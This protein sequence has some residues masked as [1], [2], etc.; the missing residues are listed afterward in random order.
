M[1]F[2]RSSP[3]RS[4]FPAANTARFLSLFFLSF[5]FKT[6]VANAQGCNN[7]QVL[8]LTGPGVSSWTAPL[9]GGPFSVR[10][11]AVGAGGGRYLSGNRNGGSGAT[12]RG[13]FTVENGETLLAIAGGPGND[14]NLEGA[15]GGG[16]S[17]VVNCGLGS[18]AGGTILILA[19]G[20]TGGQFQKTG[21]GGSA[22]TGGSG[23]G[24]DVPLPSPGTDFGGGGGGVNGDGEDDDGSG[25]KGGK[26]VSLTGLAAGGAG[27]FSANIMP[28]DNRGGDGMGGGG[29]GGDEGVGGGG[30]HTGGSGDNIDAASSFNSGSSPNNSNGTTGGGANVGSVIITCLQSL[31]VQL[32]AFK[33]V[34]DGNKVALIWRTATEKNNAGFETERSVDG[35]RWT[36]LGFVPGAG[37][38]NRLQEYTFTDENPA[39][40]VNYY[41]LKQIDRDGGVEYSHIATARAGGRGIAIHISPNPSSGGRFTLTAKDAPEGT[42]LLKIC[43]VAGKTVYET[44]CHVQGAYSAHFLAPENLPGGLYVARLEFSDGQVYFN[45]ILI[46]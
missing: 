11:E 31:P 24:G 44:N 17:G 4:L 30:G 34:G 3:L 25:G 20:G 9:S 16:G 28:S 2:I 40:G 37:T 1:N 10:I 29:G 8:N 15:G 6:A 23:N 18:C 5:V 32:I 21:V 36:R 39:P 14:S 45:K 33:A 38:F 12:M 41:R 35:R 22:S 19:A 43:N 46:R 13:T 26:Q 27:S 7:T 42:A